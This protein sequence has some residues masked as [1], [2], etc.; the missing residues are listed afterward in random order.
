MS[1]CPFDARQGMDSS[2]HGDYWKLS[3]SD[4]VYVADQAG[5]RTSKTGYG[6]HMLERQED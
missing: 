3:E 2:A 5:L 6:V 4:L 1:I